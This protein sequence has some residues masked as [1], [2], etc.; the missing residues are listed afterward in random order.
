MIDHCIVL[1]EEFLVNNYGSIHYADIFSK[2]LGNCID[3][4]ENEEIEKQLANEYVKNYFR[5]LEDYD[6]YINA[7]VIKMSKAPIGGLFS[8]ESLSSCALAICVHNSLNIAIK[9]KY[10]SIIYHALH[11][12]HSLFSEQ[13]ALQITNVCDA[14]I[15]L[16]VHMSPLVIFPYDP[17]CNLMTRTYT[18]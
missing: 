1:G 5:S 3:L 6:A 14:M 16:Q 2:F 12:R 7:Y 11:V 17:I 13:D 8:L 15:F 4:L 18:T 10:K 9:S